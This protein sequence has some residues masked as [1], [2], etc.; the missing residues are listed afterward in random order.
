MPRATS[1]KERCAARPRHAAPLVAAPAESFHSWVASQQDAAPTRSKGER[2]R[3]R[4]RLATVELLNT[5]GYRQ[6][7]VADICARAGITQPVLYR[8]FENKQALTLDVLQEFLARFVDAPRDPGTTTPYRAIYEANLRWITMAR[9]NAGLMRC[10]LDASDDEPAFAAIFARET[11][12]W[13]RRIADSVLRRFPSASTD[14]KAIEFAVTI[15]G[16]MVDELVRRLFATRSEDVR[17]LAHAVAPN[18]PTLAHFIS[19]L[20]Y[21]ALY[22]GDPPSGEGIK[23]V[24]TLVRAARTAGKRPRVTGSRTTRRPID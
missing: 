17:R 18:D 7:K 11:D 15:I 8:Y 23:V 22:G 20:W 19:V 14:R 5:V 16:G 24:P 12:R 10:L 4:I 21:R 2:T 9:A 13:N 3:D 1:A 6:L